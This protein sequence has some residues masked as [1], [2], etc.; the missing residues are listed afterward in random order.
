MLPHFQ[1]G[2]LETIETRLRN[3]V[4]N[5]R[6]RGEIKETATSSPSIT[7]GPCYFQKV[8]ESRMKPENKYHSDES[9]LL[10]TK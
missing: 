6:S 2:F 10:D 1:I 8:R 7:L 4:E 9:T 5:P 3:R